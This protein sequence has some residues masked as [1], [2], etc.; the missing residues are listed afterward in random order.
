MAESRG[1]NIIRSNDGSVL[2][3]AILFDSSNN[4]I[5]TAST[6]R[7]FEFVPTTGA[8]NTFD[9][10]DDTFKSGAITTPTVAMTHQQGENATF[11]TGIHTFR[12]TVLTDFEIGNKYIAYV[13]HASLVRAI[14]AEFQYGDLEGDMALALPLVRERETAQAGAAG[15]ITLNTN[16]SS[17]D[18]FFNDTVVFVLAGLGAG[19]ARFIFNYTGG[20]RVA[21]VFPNWIVN[22]DSTSEYIIVE[23]GA[24]PGLIAD[25]VWDE[26]LAGHV[27]V[28]SAGNALGVLTA[29]AGRANNNDLNA[30][31]GVSDSA[32]VTL[33]SQT[34]DSVWDE[35]LAATHGTAGTA[36]LF[37]RVLGSAISTRSFNNTLNALLGAPDTGS[38]DT[39]A[40][41][42]WEELAATH[43]SPGS[44]GE[45]LN[46]IAASGTPTAAEIAD[47]VWN[48]DLVAAHGAAD[49]AGLLLRA[50][51]ALI[52][53]RA[54]NPTLADL[55]AIP[56]TATATIAFPIWEENIVS[57]HGGGSTA[58]LLLRVLGAVIS[59]RVNNATLAA[60]LGVPDN[61]STNLP[62]AVADEIVDGANHTT[63]DSIGQRLA[64]IDDLTEAA[65]SGDLTAVLQQVLKID[66]DSIP[67]GTTDPDSI[68]GKL[69]TA[70][71]I[72]LN[73]D[74]NIIT[75]LNIQGP[76]L[77]IEI[78]V[79]QFG[80]VQS[81]PWT[82]AQAQI[83]DESN[84]IIATI[85]T[86]DFG[87]IGP[88]GFFTF[89]LQP[90]GLQAGQT[91]QVLVT[92]TDGGPL[93]F[94]TVKPFKIAAIA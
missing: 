59:T 63:P 74:K 10:D 67:L 13:T 60:I 17:S 64:A 21:E 3:R 2:F 83:F 54:N 5:T 38:A 26:L 25:N 69:N 93:I 80:V 33:I 50:L 44:M 22:P 87:A 72:L 8:L 82:Q 24:P 40:G 20:S 86:G 39:V 53:Q 48:E 34:V 66:L 37:L 65:G 61:P 16:A 90:H 12:Q 68:A 19:Q 73:S 91:Y 75:S 23:A 85:G 1:M 76:D 92:I 27:V 89:T 18:D 29:I 42:V 81:T 7:I 47:A 15:T 31:L 51:G 55:L 57:F 46:D 56:D 6:L 35:D 58:G 70:T 32:G 52:S 28:G 79:E 78:A 14:A 41:Q 4:P 77:R 94:S 71:A 36:G 49:S 84:A 62:D 9:F 43:N 30:L 11:D 88:R 45:I